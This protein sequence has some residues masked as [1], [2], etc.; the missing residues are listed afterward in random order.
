MREQCYMLNGKTVGLIGIGAIAKRVAQMLSGFETK[1]LYYDIVHLSKE[2]ENKLGVRYAEF[3][4]LIKTADIV[5]I[6]VPLNKGTAKMFTQKQFEMM[7]DSAIL[8]NVS[9]GGIVDEKDLINALKTHE[10]AGAGIDV[11]EQ[12]PPI[13]NNDLFKLDN[14][15][16]TSHNGGG[17]IDNVANV[18]RHAFENMQ[19][20]I[21]KEPLPEKDIVIAPK[22]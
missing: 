17:V 10:I 6:H 11:Y 21:A 1:V 4:T 3:E 8:V 2:D 5:S 12:E 16:V 20:I 14:T 19:R 22:Y 18:T 7:K 13:P 15:V 9:R